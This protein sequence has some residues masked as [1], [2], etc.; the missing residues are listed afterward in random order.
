MDIEEIRNEKLRVEFEIVNL[1]QQFKEKT[2]L[3]VTGIETSSLIEV[4]CEEELKTFVKLQVD[5]N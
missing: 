5:I 2:G 3:T 1:I 4:I